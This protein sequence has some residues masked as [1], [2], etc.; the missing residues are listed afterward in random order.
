MKYCGLTCLFWAASALAATTP[1]VRVRPALPKATATPAIGVSP[2][3]PNVRLGAK[4]TFTAT[5]T[6]LTNPTFVW[7]VVSTSATATGD[8]GSITTAGV[9]TAPAAMPTPNTVTV[10]ATYQSGTTSIVGST[11]VTLQN[12]TPVLT[13]LTPASVNTGLP[14]TI[15]L[16]GSG[17]V[18]TSQVQF[19]GTNAT[20]AK[21]ISATQFTLTGTTAAAAGSK[22]SVTVVNPNP[23]TATSGALTLSVL[24][25]VSLTV[26][27]ANATVRIG[28]T[29][30]FAAHV[31]SA[32]N[33][34][35]TWQVNGKT[36]GAAATGTIDAAGVYTPPAVAPATPSV[37]ITAVSVADP[38]KSASVTLNLQNPVPVV[39]S[40][41]PQTL[42][43]G[44]QTLTVTGSGFAPGVVVWFAGAAVT[45]NFVSDKEL[46]ASLQVSLPAGGIAAVKVVNPNPGTAT[47]N[48]V[49]IPV[50]VTSPKMTYVDAVRFLEQATF[51][52]TPAAI[53][54]LQTVGRDAWL[55]EQFAEPE[56]VWPDPLP[57]EG[58][59]RL[60]DALFTI[61][62]TGADQLRQ[63]VSLA[64]A[65][66]LVVSANKDTRFD[67]MVGF[68]R[69]L[70]HDAFGT[71]RTALG[72]ITLSPAMGIY[73]DMVNNQ[74][75]NP[76]KGTAANE[77]Y[78]RESMQLFSVGLA[79]L[80][81][82]GTPIANAAPEYDAATVTD[83]AKIFTGWTF[84]PEPGYESEFP[85]PEY[86]LAPMVANEAYHDV[87]QKTLNLPI[88]C[89]I[90]AGG[91]AL[92]DLDAALDCLYKQQ[93]VAPFVSYRLIQ[94]LV[95]SS[96]SPAYVGRVAS[97]FTTTKGNLQSVV[98]AIL[99]DPEATAE[100]TGKLREPML[101]ATTLLR[102]LNAS[103]LNNDATGV[104]GQS[105]VM[106]QIPLTPGSVFSYFSPFFRINGVVAPEFQAQNA[107]TEFGRVNYAY[108][109]VN[110]AVS[111]NVAVD[112]SNWQDL[113]SNPTQ[114]AQAINVALYRGEMNSSESAAIIGAAA[115]SK[116]PL[117]SVRDAVYA[118][119][120]A[121]QY[122]VEY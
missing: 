104:A 64:L 50:A 5:A 52:P 13:S 82:D 106:G 34:A 46:T 16:A 99:T 71:Y 72:D 111:G 65:E 76:A 41:S 7:K 33:T 35:V 69:L 85:N 119:A 96:P 29:V 22:I 121:P 10:Q 56:S 14:Y 73:L 54:H 63:R 24:A 68:Q 67:E 27:P 39:T 38:T 93:N 25:A 11:T 12:P 45:S 26:T 122:Q 83:L 109:A 98:T 110:N 103:V 53:E 9:Y 62:L 115:L 114:L 28:Q 2:A 118:A 60:Q 95:E 102:E 88:P 15:T 89:T 101:Q 105:T 19:N 78:A 113:A 77:N 81:T 59:G 55:A 112:F 32:T 70:A 87:T 31:T 108:R 6:G 18:P 47:S 30:T 21:Y 49:A 90:S 75:A 97:V 80:N 36:G 79:Q 44:T 3:L 1:A 74:K 91:S 66:I 48:I 92:T 94:R 100:G 42:S 120:A 116:T 84:A 61:G 43:T 17:F 40:L 58:V 23:G 107:E 57:S 86:D 4:Q 117:T 20:G 8:F 37:T 51:G